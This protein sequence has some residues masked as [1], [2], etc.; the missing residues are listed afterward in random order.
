[1]PKKS[2]VGFVIL[3]AVLLLSAL[4]LFAYNRY[5]AERAG[6]DAELLVEDIRSVIAAQQPS[7]EDVTAP[8]GETEPPEE[9]TEEAVDTE[10]PVVML[11]AYG[12]IGY[13]SIPDLNLEL[14]VMSEWDYTRLKYAPCRQCGSTRTD[15]LVIA[16]H[17]FSTH[18]G[19]LKELELGA[20]VCFTDMDGIESRYTLRALQTTAPDEVEAVLNSGY[21]L[22]L[23]TCTPGGA[24]RVVA[25]F[26]RAEEMSAG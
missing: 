20:E 25:F 14:P 1:M 10:M 5:E 19:R 8:T 26:D 18:F 15:D 23:Y 16:A 6:Q 21:D 13:L 4:L 9:P 24:T 7:R 22:V 12:Y 2:G 17:N 11:G 3:G